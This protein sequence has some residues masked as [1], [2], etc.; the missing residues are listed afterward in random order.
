MALFEGNKCGCT[1][2][3]SDFKSNDKNDNDCNKEC[4][5]EGGEYSGGWTCGN[6]DRY[7]VYRSFCKSFAYICMLSYI[8]MINR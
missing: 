3:I 5:Q 2:E 1:N 8:H 4:A 6:N 7:L